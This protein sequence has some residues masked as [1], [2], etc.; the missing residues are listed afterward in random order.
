MFFWVIQ[1]RELDHLN[2]AKVVGFCVDTLKFVVIGEYCSK[3]SLMVKSFVKVLRKNT[4]AGNQQNVSLL[5]FTCNVIQ[6]K[7]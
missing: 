2:I 7:R 1:I 3:G 5:S 4:L 6:N